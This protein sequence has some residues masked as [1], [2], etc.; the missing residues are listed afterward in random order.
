[1]MEVIMNSEIDDHSPE[2]N[3][4]VNVDGIDLSPGENEEVPTNLETDS[5]S[6]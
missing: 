2:P 4:R 3:T 5:I 6:N 1:M